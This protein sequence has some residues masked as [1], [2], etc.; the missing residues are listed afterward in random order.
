M[1]IHVEEPTE[2]HASESQERWLI[3]YADFITLLF[4][5]FVLLY[6]LSTST[7]KARYV[8]FTSVGM[9]MGIRPDLGLP[10]Q[11]ATHG[12][13]L[14]GAGGPRL[15]RLD[16]V[17]RKL[18][19]QLKTLPNSGVTVTKDKRG[20]IISLSAAQFFSSGQAAIQPSQLPTLNK[21]VEALKGLP[22]PVQVE[23]FTDSV[24][25]PAGS[26]YVD[27]WGL[28]AARAGNVLRYI[29][30]YSGIAPSH[31]SLAGYGPYRPVASNSTAAGRA[32]NR[33]VDIVVATLAPAPASP[34][35]T[36]AGVVRTNEQRQV[37]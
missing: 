11:L 22:N 12:G 26:P 34:V 3:S 32:R 7:D 21:V 25:L 33:R 6:A 29:L 14:S 19:E 10:P 24:P 31:L 36:A 35:T 15:H 2:E 9:S 23:G 16:W 13:I 20:L 28:S 17:K 5:L 18:L 1:A 30:Q 37:P 8:A 27:N 4:A